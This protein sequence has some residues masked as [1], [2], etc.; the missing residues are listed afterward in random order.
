M[1]IETVNFSETD[2]VQVSNILKAI[3]HPKRLKILC[4]LMTGAKSVNEIS[5]F[6]KSSQPATSQFLSKM[7]K[8]N[9]LSSHR[10][11]TTIFYTISDKRIKTLFKTLKTQFCNQ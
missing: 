10:D 1:N 8:E 3:A 4:H 11:K 5:K 6:C 9:I 7:T 2:A